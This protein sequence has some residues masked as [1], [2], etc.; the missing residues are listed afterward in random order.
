M[1]ELVETVLRGEWALASL[2][3]LLVARWLVQRL[4]A[5]VHAEVVCILNLS[6]IRVSLR[7]YIRGP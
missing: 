3:L 4:A 7:L 5:A 6:R 1:K 2:L